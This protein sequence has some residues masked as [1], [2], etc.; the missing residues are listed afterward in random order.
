MGKLLEA[1]VGRHLGP[2]DRLGR[3]CCQSVGE[4]R[5]PL[6]EL[7]RRHGV[8]DEADA[9]GFGGGH[10][11]AGH[12]VLLGA[13][14]ADEL[15]P[16][17]G[18]A[19]ASD[20]ADADMRVADLRVLGG[21]DDVA[22]EGDRG[23]QAGGVT[24]ELGNHGLLAIEQRVDDLLAFSRRLLERCRLVDHSLHPV[25]VAAGREGAAGAGEHG[26][27]ARRIV[28][29]V[30]EHMRQ[31][32]VHLFVDGVEFVGPVHRDLENAAAAREPQGLVGIEFHESIRAGKVAGSVGWSFR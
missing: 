30:D 10:E 5:Y 16:D 18:A 25:D 4:L 3:T 31:F 8:V 17:H 32:G 14:I 19:I 21:E 22:K 13:G 23:A 20:E 11:V 15:G 27:V 2:A 12:Q 9:L 7:G 29:H 24:V 26:D 1:D 6:V 28:R